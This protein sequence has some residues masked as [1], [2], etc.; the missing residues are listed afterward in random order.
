MTNMPTDFPIWYSTVEATPS[1]KTAS[2]WR[3]VDQ[4]ISELPK[5]D[6][7]AL[8]R[9]ALRTRHSAAQ[10]ASDAFVE[11]VRACDET[12]DSTAADREIQILAAS[13]L[14]GRLSSS[15][16]DA[17]SLTTAGLDGARKP[18]LPM[19]LFGL[20]ENAVRRLAVSTR[21][22]LELK[23]LEIPKVE[24]RTPPEQEAEMTPSSVGD[25]LASTVNEA[26]D[27]LNAGINEKLRQIGRRQD[28]ADE[29][30]Q[31]LWWLIGGQMSDGE[32]I[33]SLKA[34]VRPLAVG[35]ELAARTSCCP[36]PLAIPALLSRA[37]ITRKSSI[38]VVDAVNAM[39]EAWSKETVEDLAISPVTHPIHEAVRR[40][41]ETGSGG[42]WVRPW[43]AWC[44]IDQDAAL[45]PARLSELFYRERLLLTR[46]V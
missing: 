9:M 6:V 11:N 44:E 2:R 41:T 4:A 43:S 33:Q 21:R 46:S 10:A 36:G 38:K 19:D 31:M 45:T 32:K 5:A 23:E 39:S 1:G 27:A 3:G 28:V 37:G 40:R 7:E 30:L 34:S 20:A 18:Q 26:L 13:G 17:L 35:R 15:S 24:W 25:G 16:V 14:A 22:R 42:D 12:F 8:V 29:E